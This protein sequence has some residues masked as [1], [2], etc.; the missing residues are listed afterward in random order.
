MWGRGAVAPI[1]LG[2]LKNYF[3][4]VYESITAYINLYLAVQEPKT[5][6]KY[7]YAKRMG[8]PS[9]YTPTLCEHA[10]SPSLPKKNPVYAPLGY[11]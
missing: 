6:V 3:Y 9:S 7:R 1:V 11:R 4:T 5:K 2:K 8:H 10:N